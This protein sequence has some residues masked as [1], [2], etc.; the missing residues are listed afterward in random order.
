MV[1]PVIT[2]SSLVVAII[3]VGVLLGSLHHQGHI[4]LPM[5]EVR[6]WL[7]WEHIQAP[8]HGNVHGNVQDVW[9][10]GDD[11]HEDEI[12]PPFDDYSVR[13]YIGVVFRR[14]QAKLMGR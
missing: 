14:R 8:L 10:D 3:L 2:L 13:I 6:E 1:R 4:M 9:M 5:D 7:Q 11:E 12:I